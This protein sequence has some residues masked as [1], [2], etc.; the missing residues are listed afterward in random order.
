LFV[1][2]YDYQAQAADELTFSVGEVMSISQQDPSGWWEAIKS[3]GTKVFAKEKY[4]A[5]LV[6]Y[7]G[8]VSQGMESGNLSQTSLTGA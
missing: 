8:I 6:S 3:D 1:T 5:S 7:T 4:F 2:R